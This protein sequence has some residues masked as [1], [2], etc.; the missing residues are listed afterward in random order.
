MGGTIT[1]IANTEATLTGLRGTRDSG[2]LTLRLL[3]ANME[4]LVNVAIAGDKTQAAN[5]GG[6]LVTRTSYAATAD[7]PLNTAATALGGGA[8]EA[9]CK[10]ERGVVCFLMQIGTDPAHPEAWAPPTISRGCKHTFSGLAAGTKVYARIAVVRTGNV[11]STWSDV[12]GATVWSSRS[13]DPRRVPRFPSRTGSRLIQ[14]RQHLGQ[15]RGPAVEPALRVVD[16][17]RLQ[18]IGNRLRLHRLGHRAIPSVTPIRWTDSTMARWRALSGRS[19][20]NIPS[21]FT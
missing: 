15:R 16:P 11:Q 6:T 13:G 3:H 4:S 1:T 18:Q 12:V 10:A 2:I 8:V 17:N 21:I 7:P 20:T 19:R 5:W 9:K 14:L